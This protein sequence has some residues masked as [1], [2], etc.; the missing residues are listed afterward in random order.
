MAEHPNVTLLRRAH[1]AFNK[2]DMTTLTGVIG[3]DVVWHL[4]GSSVLS[5]EHRGREAVF[6][7]FRRM[8]ELS[9]GTFHTDVHDIVG[10]DDHTVAEF[11]VAGSREGKQIKLL[12]ADVYHVRDGQIT[13]F[14]T[15][16]HEDSR[17]WDEFW[18]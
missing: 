1:E 11:W 3:E 7:V 9:G 17:T 15:F 5:G 12:T 8:G 4:P 16:F 13:E 6:S 14:W 18:S 10:N 2:A